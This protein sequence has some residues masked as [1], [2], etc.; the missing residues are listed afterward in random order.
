MLRRAAI[1]GGTLLALALV[2][3]LTLRIAP[4]LSPEYRA[5]SRIHRLQPT[6]TAVTRLIKQ[7]QV[8]GGETYAPD[9][10]LGALLGPFRKDTERTPDY[11]YIRQTDH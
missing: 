2:G 1:A 11:T 4:S 6:R 9:P 5:R 3:E 7:Q 8:A 10:E